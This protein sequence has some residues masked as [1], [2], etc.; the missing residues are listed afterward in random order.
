MRFFQP[1]DL[2]YRTSYEPKP[3]MIDLSDVSQGVAQCFLFVFHWLI[4][5]STFVVNG[6]KLGDVFNNKSHA[7]CPVCGK[8]SC[9]YDDLIS[10]LLL[11]QVLQEC[12]HS[13][14]I[15]SSEHLPVQAHIIQSIVRSMQLSA[16]LKWQT[17]KSVS[18]FSCRF[19]LEESDHGI[20]KTV[21]TI[22]LVLVSL[23]WLVI[24]DV[25]FEVHNVPVM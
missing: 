13:F 16:K 2:Q 18:F 7:L 12:G 17:I 8:V 15:W 6:A 9:W 20:G 19:R 3:N 25:I 1:L 23:S 4:A 5:L 24:S 10:S 22:T 21:H 11:L 14:L